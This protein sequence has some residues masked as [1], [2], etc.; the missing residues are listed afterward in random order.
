MQLNF[1]VWRAI[2]VTMLWQ[3]PRFKSSHHPPFL[4]SF[5]ISK[6][7]EQKNGNLQQVLCLKK[8]VYGKKPRNTYKAQTCS[9]TG[10]G[11]ASGQGERRCEWHEVAVWWWA[12]LLH[13]LLHALPVGD[14][15]VPLQMP[16]WVRRLHGEHTEIIR[17]THNLYKKDKNMTKFGFHSLW[18]TVFCRICTTAESLWTSCWSCRSGSICDSLSSSLPS[19]PGGALLIV[20]LCLHAALSMTWTFTFYITFTFLLA[21]CT[22]AEACHQHQM[23]WCGYL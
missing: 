23:V 19:P 17:N 3:H 7:L 12:L 4:P 20:C 16:R 14:H 13:R 11:E 9:G 22:E 6:L 5:S 2:L 21:F 10:E 15:R 8:T 1:K 18:F